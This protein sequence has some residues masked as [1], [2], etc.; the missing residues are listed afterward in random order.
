MSWN[1]HLRSFPWGM[2]VIVV[3]LASMAV[4]WIRDGRGLGKC[5]VGNREWEAG[6]AFEVCRVLQGCPRRWTGNAVVACGQMLSES[7]K[8]WMSN[9]TASGGSSIWTGGERRNRIVDRR[10][11]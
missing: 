4:V 7:K 11:G 1:K 10:M 2:S 9:Q 8:P 5:S 6:M 3:V